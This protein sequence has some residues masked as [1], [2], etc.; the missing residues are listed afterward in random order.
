MTKNM[1]IHGKWAGYAETTHDGMSF[2]AE[3]NRR[4]ASDRC[5]SSAGCTA[6]LYRSRT[7][8]TRTLLMNAVKLTLH[9][10]VT[11]ENASITGVLSK[12]ARLSHMLLHRLWGRRTAINTL[13][14]NSDGKT[15]THLMRST[16]G[17]ES[18]SHTWTTASACARRRRATRLK[19]WPTRL[20]RNR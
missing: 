8:V 11:H 20:R 12:H 9:H 14:R 15:G 6:C 17:V 13:L 10:W 4:V 18:R 5:P 2:R 19:R 1:S 7:S 16:V 3:G